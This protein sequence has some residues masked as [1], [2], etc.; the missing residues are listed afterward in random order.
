MQTERPD[1]DQTETHQ[2]WYEGIG[3]SPSAGI[4]CPHTLPV[5][6]L[7]VVLNLKEWPCK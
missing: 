2:S 6:E 3:A 4:R 5:D 1:L 7:Q